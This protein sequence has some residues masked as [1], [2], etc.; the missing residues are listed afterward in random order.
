MKKRILDIMVAAMGLVLLSPVFLAI[1]A[2]IKWDSEGPAFFLQ[3]R[4]GRHGCIFRII[5]FR[6]M[7][8]NANVCLQLTIGADR[9]VTKAGQFLRRHKIDE[10][11]QLLN[12]LT[13]SMSLVGPRPEVPRYV[14]CYPPALRD[15]VLSVRPGIT[16]WAAIEFKDESVVLGNEEDAERKYTEEVLPIKL[17]YYVRYVRDR[18]FCTDLAIIMRTLHAVLR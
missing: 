6:T 10:L 8:D 18:T 2:W 3:H 13:G 7:Y 16:D 15:L 12:V 11:P 5:K 4:V 9:R 17:N 14:S 1:A